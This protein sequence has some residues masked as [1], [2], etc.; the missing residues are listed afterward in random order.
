MRGLR[1]QVSDIDDEDIMTKEILKDLDISGWKSPGFRAAT[2]AS[3]SSRPR[4]R[5]AR[6]Q[7]SKPAFIW[8]L[9]KA[10]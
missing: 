1:K 7:S 2:P 4:D 3:S 9:K 10:G 5:R 6:S 8:L